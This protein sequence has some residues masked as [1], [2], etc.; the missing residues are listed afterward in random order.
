VVLKHILTPVGFFMR[1]PN[2]V[3]VLFYHRVNTHDFKAL[4]MV[5]RELSVPTNRF[6]AQMAYLSKKGFK[7][8]S[9]GQCRAMLAGEVPLDPKAVLLT[10]DDGYK[11]NLTDAAPILAKFGFTATV[12]PVLDYIGHDNRC[13]P[14]CDEKGLGDFMSKAE[15]RAWLD[16]GHEIGSH[17]L[18]HPIL[19][20]P[21]SAGAS[22]SR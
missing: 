21:P 12:F 9:Q 11:D 2:G 4:G 16:A 5:S 13:W 10:F 17:T 20:R 19:T 3:R 22:G 14:M 18:S 15:L 7:T 6:H 8:I 1:R